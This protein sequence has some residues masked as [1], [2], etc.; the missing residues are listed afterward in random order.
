MKQIR[1]E[2]P[3]NIE[4]AV[5]L[6]NENRAVLHG[7]GVHLSGKRIKDETT[8]VSLDKLQLNYVKRENGS[9]KIGSM[10]DFQTV[11]E[12]LNNVMP[13]HILAKSLGQAATTPLRNR[14]TIGGSLGLAPNWS[15]LIGPLIALNAEV[16]L[17]GAVSG[18]H[19][20][21]DYI[22]QKE[23]NTNTLITEVIIP[24]VNFESWYYREGIIKNDHPVFTI[25]LLTK[26]RNKH[27]EDLVVVLT[28]HTQRFLRLNSIE[29]KLKGQDINQIEFDNVVKGLDVKFPS[30]RGMSSD[31]IR[32]LAEV[33]IERGLTEL[34]KS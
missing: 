5:G 2:F 21:A 27:V 31:Y 13:A 3:K 9:I 7:G 18:I 28:G 22:L 34:L 23:L 24:S 17:E 26:Q 1:W 11:S 10:T 6:I 8:F 30:V 14:I 29:E 33:Q 4:E 20:V 32:H 25:T 16:K 15:D 12:Q 19:H